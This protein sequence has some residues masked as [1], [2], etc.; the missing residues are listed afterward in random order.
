M[1]KLSA[2]YWNDRY[3]SNQTGW[4]IGHASGPI[5]EYCKNILDKNIRILI[6]GCGNAY[7]A[8]YLLSQGFQNITLID[9]SESLCQK[10]SAKF[11]GTPVRVICGN[12][13]DHQETYD[14]VLEQTFFCALDRDLR[15]S[16][17][18]KMAQILG[19]NGT[20]AGVLFASE[21]NREG[22]PFGGNANEYQ[23]IFSDVFEQV[24]I[25][26]CN[27]SISARSGNELF[28]EIKH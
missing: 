5:V 2:D 25:K 20:L 27:N 23:E 22:P 17:A 8:E 28:I 1:E 18:Q 4:D 7:E 10:L 13:F 15:R 19:T 12:F 26:P 16:Y 9:L 14:L 21:F 3:L 6:P 24:C 11:S